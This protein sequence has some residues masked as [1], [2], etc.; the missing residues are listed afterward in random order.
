VA[1]G[2]C[3]CAAL[4]ACG[5]DSAA[6]SG[7]GAG[8]ASDGGTGGLFANADPTAPR[9][10]DRLADAGFTDG[11]VASLDPCERIVVRGMDL[12]FVVDD[13]ASMIEEQQ[14]LR[15]EFPELIRVLTTG[16]RDG[17]GRPEFPGVEDLHLGVVSSDMGVVGT[18]GIGSCEGFGDDG[19]MQNTPS[20]SLSDCMAG[21]PRFLT[22]TAGVDDPA[23]SAR[24]FACI[25]SLGTEGCGYEQP[26]ESALKALWPSADDRVRFLTD[27]TG[28]GGVGHGDVEN[29]GF[30]RQAMGDEATVLAIVVVSDEE[31]CSSAVTTHFTPSVYLAPEDP[32]AMQDLNLRCYHN[33][34]NLYVVQRYVEGF[35]QVRPGLEELVVFGAIVGVPPDLVEPAALAAVDFDDPAQ[36]DAFYDAILADDRMQERPDP[37]TLTEGVPDLIPSCETDNGKAYP[38]RRFV[39]VA[40]QFGQNGIVQSICQDDFGPAIDVIVSA[41]GRTVDQACIVE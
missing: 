23:A 18:P 22:Y 1:C 20:P 30:A 9:V 8:P 32:L 15:R 33:P 2:A 4:V 26:L 41:I 38:P 25:A 21:Y 16:D 37:D 3:L 34:Q 17:D 31:D 40:R 29:A 36:R 39:E 35:R 24:D 12:L 28:D 13:S 14:A 19:V 7:S 10:H 11:G 6:D 27:A 5:G